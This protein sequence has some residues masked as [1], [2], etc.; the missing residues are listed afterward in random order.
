MDTPKNQSLVRVMKKDNKVHVKDVVEAQRKVVHLKVSIL[1]IIEVD[2]LKESFTADVFYQARWREPKLD[3]NKGS[4]NIDWTTYWNP[5]VFL[6]NAI[7]QRDH[8]T[9]FVL[10]SDETGETYIVEKNRMVA[11][12]TESMELALFPFDIQDL[13]IFITTTLSEAEV[14]FHEDDREIS[15]VHTETFAKKQEWQIYEFVHFTPKVLTQEYA[16]NK[17]KKPGMYVF[18]SA[19]RKPGFFMWNVIVLM[20]IISSLALATFAVARSKIENRLQLSIMLVLVTVTFKFVTNQVIPKISYMTH[21]DRYI[22]GSTIFLYLIAMWH[23]GSETLV[24]D[25][26]LLSTLDQYAFYGFCGLFGLIQIIFTLIVVLSG[27]TRRYG[28]NKKLKNYH[29]KRQNIMR[30]VEIVKTSKT[31]TLVKK[32]TLD[33]SAD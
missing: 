30:S 13:N 2:T 19:A 26:D 16:N 10:Q 4:D 9:W 5:K 14:G 27:S 7:A 15:S 18:C 1:N 11:T 22:I 23:A 20:C 21:L 3:G 25:D 24:T 31:N 32:Q 33:Y 17:F 12:F 8:A 6:S 28:V 29:K